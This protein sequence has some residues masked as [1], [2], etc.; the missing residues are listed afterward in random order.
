[1]CE[2]STN[3]KILIKYITH[4]L[5]LKDLAIGDHSTEVRFGRKMRVREEVGYGDASSSKN[6]NYCLP[7][8]VRLF[9]CV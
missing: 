2:F 9:I 5:V 7:A 8:S 6:C 4:L 1:M 3:Y